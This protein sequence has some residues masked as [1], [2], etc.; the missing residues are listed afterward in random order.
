MKFECLTIKR[1]KIDYMQLCEI[2][3][4]LIDL[5]VKGYISSINDDVVLEITV[6]EKNKKWLQKMFPDEN[7]ECTQYVHF[8]AHLE[9][10]DE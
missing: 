9:E 2:Y 5:G 3:D 10:D 1:T 8:V 7:F 4:N 6:N